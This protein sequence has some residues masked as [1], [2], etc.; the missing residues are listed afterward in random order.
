MFL[1]RVSSVCMPVIQRLKAS[2]ESKATV[3]CQKIL[4]QA[5]LSFEEGTHHQLDWILLKL[6]GCLCKEHGTRVASAK[7]SW[8]AMKHFGYWPTDR[9]FGLPGKVIFLYL[10][11]P[12]ATQ[13]W[14]SFR[15]RLKSESIL[16]SN[17]QRTSIEEIIHWF[18][19]I[20]CISLQYFPSVSRSSSSN[21]LGCCI[22]STGS[23]VGELNNCQARIT[24][25]PIWTHWTRCSNFTATS[26]LG[27]ENHLG[28]V[29]VDAGGFLPRKMRKWQR[30]RSTKR[31]DKM[32]SN[33]Q[34]E[35]NR[36][37]LK[38]T[39]LHRLPPGQASQAHSCFP[40]GRSIDDN[41]K[42]QK[43]I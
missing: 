18:F 16:K 41:R 40:A 4:S 19:D 24:I 7:K 5:S 25:G 10:Y 30:L 20:L 14:F 3:F 35:S 22:S 23:W 39:K 26:C 29:L 28:E 6:T 12:E 15:F 37:A 34:T 8:T 11:A 1:F 38:S 27:I 2:V 42:Q 17:R 32:R 36:P 31:W 43:S 21:G 13:P 9:A 33:D